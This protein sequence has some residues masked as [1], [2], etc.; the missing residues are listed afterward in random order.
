MLF[1][2]F[3]NWR[4]INHPGPLPPFAPPS[5]TL[6]LPADS[7]L[8]S[9]I[10]AACPVERDDEALRSCLSNRG[11]ITAKEFD[12]LRKSYPVRRDFAGI[13]VTHCGSN[14]LS[15]SLHGLGFSTGST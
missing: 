13:K 1:A 5:E 11:R 3:L 4:G 12:Q 9:A 8:E 14:C 2:E 15:E 10:L 6:N 7:S